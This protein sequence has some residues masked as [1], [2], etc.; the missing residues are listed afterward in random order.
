MI[1]E[2]TADAKKENLLDFGLSQFQASEHFQM[3]VH[4][5]STQWKLGAF[6]RHRSISLFLLHH[7][8]L[9]LLLSF[10][11]SF[12]IAFQKFIEIF[13]HRWHTDRFR[14]GFICVR[15]GIRLWNV[16]WLVLA[17]IEQYV[18]S[19]N[20]ITNFTVNGT[21]RWSRGH[22]IKRWKQYWA[23]VCHQSVVVILVCVDGCCCCYYKIVWPSNCY[24]HFIGSDHNFVLCDTIVYFVFCHRWSKQMWYAVAVPAVAR[25]RTIISRW[26]FLSRFFSISPSVGV[27]TF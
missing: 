21:Y 6:F 10:I 5:F 1:W 9:P 11:V 17:K 12:C 26:F 19:N 18:Y 4:F 15:I 24:S 3:M 14:M 25:I 27:C 13:T 8:T 16:L 2:T 23:V 7:A 22:S 20:N